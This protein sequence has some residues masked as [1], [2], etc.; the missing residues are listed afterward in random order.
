MSKNLRADMHIHTRASDGVWTPKELMEE[1]DGEG[2]ELFAVTDHNTVGS[3]AEA[4]E[5]AEEAG[6]HFLP[7]VEIDTTLEGNIYHIIGYDIDIEDAALNGMI[8]RN[9]ELMENR[10]IESLRILEAAGFPVDW[11]DYEEYRHEP[12][13]GGWKLLNYCID[14]GFCSDAPDYFTRLFN[15]NRPIP[16]PR[17]PH[18][19]EAIRV[20]EKAGGVPVLAHPFG[21]IGGEY[22]VDRMEVFRKIRDAGIKGLECFSTYHSE[23]QI[24]QAK[25]FCN[26]NELLVTGGSDSH[27]SFTARRKL[28]R[29][30]V[31]TADL[32]LGELA[33]RAGLAI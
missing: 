14:R 27:G 19:A 29:P 15:D 24:R 1:L 4:G 20:I 3:V 9:F 17:Y 30:H 16:H 12:A 2:I 33:E 22:G 25:S 13:R 23:E 31:T 11:E 8:G 28:G 7:A 21:S 5:L 6:L 10:D 32:R 26:E 18:P